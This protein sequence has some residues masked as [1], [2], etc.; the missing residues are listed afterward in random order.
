MAAANRLFDLSLFFAILGTGKSESG[1]PGAPVPSLFF[2]T[3]LMQSPFVMIVI[4]FHA[5]KINFQEKGFALGLALKL[6]VL[7]LSSPADGCN[8]SPK[9]R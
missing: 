4:C 3:R 7:E 8:A 2:K 5:N 1:A 9:L 6:R